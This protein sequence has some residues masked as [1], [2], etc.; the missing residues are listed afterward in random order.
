MTCS[1]IDEIDLEIPMREASH[2]LKTAR[3]LAGFRSARAAA[4]AF[5]WPESAY[6]AHEAGTRR[7]SD[8]L[9]ARYLATFAID[10]AQ[11]E[12]AI[13]Q[14]PALEF[15]RRSEKY[16]RARR[17]T[18]AR[19]LAGFTTAKLASNTYNF[20]EQS[21]Y[22]HE[23]GRH[24]ISEQ[25]ANLYSLAFGVSACWLFDG[26][27]PSGLTTS[28][29]SELLSPLIDDFMNS[30]ASEI[31][32]NL[33]RF[34]CKDRRAPPEA[35]AA[36]RAKKAKAST[37][38]KATSIAGDVVEVVREGVDKGKTSAWGFPYGFLSHVWEVSSNNLRIVALS[39]EPGSVNLGDRVLIDADNASV[40]VGTLVA[41]RRGDRIV[42]LR[43]SVDQDSLQEGEVLGRVVA[44]ISRVG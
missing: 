7:P 39:A 5:S 38:P 41:V 21:Y 19:N 23:S 26:V 44:R 34:V 8:Q 43:A 27:G 25:L 31:P 32:A 33:R 3:K 37:L 18:L 14:G 42:T 29:E 6:A 4:L 20:K 12:K 36:Y 11:L 30:Y 24:G 16:R 17:L 15:Y 10:P 22:A 9:M 35:I 1:S 40:V 28:A 13:R 2:R